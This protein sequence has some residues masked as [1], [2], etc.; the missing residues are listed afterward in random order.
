MADC[1]VLVPEKTLFVFSY[2]FQ[3]EGSLLTMETKLGCERA[4]GVP[5]EKWVMLAMSNRVNPR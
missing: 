4:G 3:L 1:L 5:E 2:A